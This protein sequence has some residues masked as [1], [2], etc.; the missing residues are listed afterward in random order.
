M[1]REARKRGVNDGDWVESLTA[2]VEHDDGR[3]QIIHWARHQAQRQAAA[4][5]LPLALSG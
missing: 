3:L 5:E 1:A 4:A 2:L